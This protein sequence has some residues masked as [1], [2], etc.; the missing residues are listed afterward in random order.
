[1]NLGYSENVFHVEDREI[2]LKQND[3][4][5][6]TTDGY[7]D[8]ADISRQ[9]FGSPKFAKLIATTY[10]KSIEEQQEIF[11]YELAEHS[12]GVIQRDDITVFGIKL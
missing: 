8:Q 12:K 5:Y 10:S 1:L 2:I 3:M 11:E 4:I 6:L 7:I 9:R